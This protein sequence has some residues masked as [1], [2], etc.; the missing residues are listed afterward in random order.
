MN[1]M[2]GIPGTRPRIIITAATGTH[3]R[4]RFTCLPIWVAMSFVDDTR[5]TMIA[6]AIDSNSDG[7]CATRP[8]PTDNRT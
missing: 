7:I 4:D 5:V 3:A 2:F 1:N 6:V 8:S